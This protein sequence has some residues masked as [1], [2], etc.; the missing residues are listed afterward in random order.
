MSKCVSFYWCPRTTI[1]GLC[2]RGGLVP[3]VMMQINGSKLSITLVYK[4]Y[5]Q[6]MYI[7]YAAEA[8]LAI[9]SHSHYL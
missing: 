4:S 2:G 7:P 3:Q 9:A 8:N 6:C 1:I 5:L